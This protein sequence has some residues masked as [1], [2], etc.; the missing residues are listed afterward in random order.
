MI[1]PLQMT[2][3]SRATRLTFFIAGFVTATWAVIV[4]YARANTGVNEATLGTLLLCLGLGA[5]IAMPVTG[6]LTSRFGCRR[7]IVSAIALVIMSTPMLAVMTDPILLGITLLVFGIGVGV[8]DCAMN[9]QAIL[10][11]KAS[12]VPLMSG[13]HGMYSFGGIAGA[14]LMTLLL[15]LGINVVVA[16]L[17]IT[18]T[19]IVL[20]ILSYPGLLTYANPKEGPAFAVPRG[21]VLLLGLVC[22]LVFLTE[23]TVL[24]WSAVYLTQ[25]RNMP[26]TLGGLGYTCFAV[27]MTVARLTGDRLIKNMGRF[28]VVFGGAVTAAAGLALV[29][30]VPSWHLSLLGYILVGAGCANIVPVM[31]SAVGQQRVMPQAVAVPAMTTMGYL[32]VLSGP[33]MIGYVAHFSSLAIAFSLIMALM[34]FVGAI[35]FTLNL[36]QNHSAR[37]NV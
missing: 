22:F 19:V 36:G 13:F 14:G 3:S 37:E 7:V 11:E 27:A 1:H 20:S 2:S 12:Q 25:V 31:F 15:A 33:A 32:G 4:P 35:S 17:L 28:T 9:I 30:F 5:L 24:D 16:T 10:V 18:L 34:L 8:T 6:S 29:T 23:G 26:E 21:I